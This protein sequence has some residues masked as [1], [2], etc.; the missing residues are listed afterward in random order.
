M[1]YYTLLNDVLES[2]KHF[3]RLNIEQKVAKA[4]KLEYNELVTQSELRKT[5]QQQNYRT[6]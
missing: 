1:K 6:K 2:L 4:K 5:A 3:M